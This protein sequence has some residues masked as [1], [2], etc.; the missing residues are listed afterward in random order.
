MGGQP[1]DRAGRRQHDRDRA[2]LGARPVGAAERPRRDAARRTRRV[3]NTTRSARGATTSTPRACCRLDSTRRRPTSRCRSTPTCGPATTSTSQATSRSSRRRTSGIAQISRRLRV[4]RLRASSDW[5]SAREHVRAPGA[6]PARDPARRVCPSTRVPRDI[7]AVGVARMTAATW[8]SG[9]RP[10]P[11]CRSRPRYARFEVGIDNDGDGDAEYIVYNSALDARAGRTRPDLGHLRDRPSATSP[12]SSAYIVPAGASRT[13]SPDYGEFGS[14]PERAL[15]PG[16]L[17]SASTQA[18]LDFEYTVE[19]Y[20][21]RISGPI[22]T[23][24]PL[25]GI[26][27]TRRSPRPSTTCSR[28]LRAGLALQLRRRP[29][30]PATARSGCSCSTTSTRAPSRPS[31]PRSTAADGRSRAAPTR[32]TRA[33]DQPRRLRLHRSRGRPADLSAG[34]ST[35]TAP[36][37]R[38]A[39]RRRVRARGRPRDAGRSACASATATRSR[40]SATS[41]SASPT[42]PRRSR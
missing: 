36:T 35:T 13:G 34:I 26:A 20:A 30:P 5:Y 3:G 22:D 40:S 38:A 10:T 28:R 8:S 37:R 23:V 2:D 41:R 15:D 14:H 33:D 32:A 6:Q 1:V 31:R 16:G 7:R 21:N 29:R 17:R 18:A 39:R 42:S 24:G 9:S 4:S 11:R 12:R 19:G 25:S 27:S